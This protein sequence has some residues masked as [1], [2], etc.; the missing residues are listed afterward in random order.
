MGLNLME[1]AQFFHNREEWRAWLEAHHNNEDQIWL[2]HY[3][4]RSGKGRLSVGE[5]VE[6]AICF[7]WIDGKLRRIDDDKHIVRFSPRKKKSVWSKTNKERAKRMIESGRMT[8]AG[9]AK[10]EEAKRSDYWDDAYTNKVKEKM[11][12][13]LKNALTRDKKAWSSFQ[14]FANTYRNMYIGW[15]NSARTSETRRNRI[16]KVVEQSLQ[17]K[18]YVFL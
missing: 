17:N 7:G 9:L 14:N 16:R 13:D 6:E 18:K 12:A 5:G 10:I 11:P 2:V 1:D 3:K 4:K 8:Q 15:I